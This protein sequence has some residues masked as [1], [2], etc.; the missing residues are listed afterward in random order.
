MGVDIR[1]GGQSLE[2]AAGSSLEMNLTN[3]HL[4]YSKI[5][6]STANLPGLPLTRKNQQIFG[7]WEQPQAGAILRRQR[8]EQYY[9]GQLIR[10]A[11]FLLTEAGP[12]G[13]QG[14]M[15]E[16]LGEFFGDW[17]NV[18]LSQ[19][20]LGSVVLPATVP[21]EV[22]DGTALQLAFPTILNPDFY[23][24]SGA[25]VS[26]SGRV[27]DYSAGSY[28]N[29]AAKPIVPM[30]SLT[31]L[32]RKIALATSTSIDGA[33]L[34]HPAYSRLLLYNTRALD[35]RSS[36]SLA[37]HLPEL[38]IAELLLELRKLFNL[39]LD[40]DLPNR[41]LTVG[42]WGTALG[43]AATVDWTDKAV[44]RPLKTPEPN[45]RLQLG[46]E[47]DGGDASMK[48]K[49]ALLADYLSPGTGS[50]ATLKSRISTLLPDEI[51]GTAKASQPG[52]TAQFSQLTGSFAPRLLFWHGLSGGMPKALGHYGGYSLYWNGYASNG[53]SV[54]GL[55]QHWQTLEAMRAQQF[56][57]KQSFN[58]TETDLA[59]LRWDRKVHVAGVD[60]LVVNATVSLPIRKPV[61]CLLVAG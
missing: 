47:L 36:I 61:E 12:S 31:W 60:Y 54:P 14:Q 50:L 57:A 29:T 19:L 7:Y 48:D 44:G 37:Q 22:L 5:V 52:V 46:Y 25:G 34:T 30:L 6:G 59:S 20:A 49:P 1:I 32:L 38:S 28:G 45:T 11:T 51:T 43:R 35:G 58:L 40:F 53:V 16:L 33:F 2:L 27:N 13:Y 8:L 17:Q 42:F 23:G 18:P 26:Y 15:V 3:P 41:R 4:D 21:P 39:Q 24:S 9:N 10:E 55:V 56:Y